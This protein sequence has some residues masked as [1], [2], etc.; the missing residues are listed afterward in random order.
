MKVT[1]DL[2]IHSR[3]SRATSKSITIPNLDK[4]CQIKG[5]DLIGTGD[6][7]H[8]EWFREIKKHLKEID[9]TGI[10]EHGNTRFMLT[11]ELS[12]MYSQEGR[13][14]RVHFVI[15]A[16]SLDVASQITDWLKTKGRV[17]YDGRPIFGFP[18]TEL[19]ENIEN[20]RL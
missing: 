7:T 17:D 6:F 8:P 14:R 5:L 16:P 2:H 3:F 12:L 4:Y 9:N 1:A 20:L 18:A 10:F 19:T 13:G 11:T 15:L